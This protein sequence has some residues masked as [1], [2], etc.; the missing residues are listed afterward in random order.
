[1]TFARA[2]RGPRFRRSPARVW[3][4]SMT[5]FLLPTAR[6]EYD[7]RKMAPPTANA[8]PFGVFGRRENRSISTGERGRKIAAEKNDSGRREDWPRDR[9]D[10]GAR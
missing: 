2:N 10:S 9:Y 3:L 1:M 7:R 6:S 4:T 5:P 8:R